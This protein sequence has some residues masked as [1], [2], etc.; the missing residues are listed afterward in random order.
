MRVLVVG[1]GAV[2]SLLGWTLRSGGAQ[3]WIAHRSH[4]GPPATTELIVVDLDSRRRAV[5]V[6]VVG[7]PD[8]LGTAPD[9]ILLA[10]K[11]FDLAGA[12]HGC[13]AWPEAPVL[14]VQNGIGAEMLVVRARPQARLI[15]GSLT[16]SVDAL[17]GG[18]W[19]R[20]TRGGLGLAAVEGDVAPVIEQLGAIL[21]DG[22]LATRTYDDAMAMKWS[23]LLGNLSA[24]AVAALLDYDPGRIYRHRRLFQIERDQLREALAVMRKLR[25]QPVALPGA[26][27]RLLARAVDLPPW[28]GRAILAPIM[29][30]ARGG[31]EPS[32][33]IQSH[34]DRGPSEVDWLNGA[35]A[36]AGERIGVATPINRR[37]TCL[38]HEV[39]ADPD[40]RAWFRHRPGRLID[41]LR[42]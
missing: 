24:N 19:R 6:T 23:K 15:A 27:I 33:R 7:R 42:L 20:R 13:S 8:D 26:D 11:M 16:V 14:T 38:V 37:L 40:R 39:L 29:G 25:L 22:G 2:G 35:V 17:E 9:V 18:I 3:V 31:K 21:E 10:V 41:A 30:R 5:E 12:V 36:R 28:I 4:E 34:A 1:G 32:L